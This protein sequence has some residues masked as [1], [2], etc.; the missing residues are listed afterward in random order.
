MF[1]RRKKRNRNIFDIG[2]N[3]CFTCDMGQLVPFCTREVVP[4]D[5]IKGQSKIFLRMTPQLAPIF[6][7]C[8]VFTH[9]FY[10]PFRILWK[11]FED[12]Y[13]GGKDYT[14]LSEAVKPYVLLTDSAKSSL[15][16]YLGYGVFSNLSKPLKCDA[17]YLRAYNKIWNDY[18][19]NQNLQDEIEI[20]NDDGEDPINN[21]KLLR[22]NWMKDIYT[23]ALPAPQKGP[24]VL[25]PLGKSAPVVSNGELP[26]YSSDS[27]LNF[28]LTTTTNL[29]TISQ[30]G[31][32]TGAAENLKY[33]DQT[34]LEVDLENASG[35]TINSFRTANKLQQWLEKNAR[36]GNRFIDTLLAHFGVISDD[37]RLQRAEYL[38]GGASQVNFS[39]VLQTSESTTTSPLANMAGHA[40]AVDISHTFYKKIKEPGILMGICSIMPKAMYQQG[41][42]KRLIKESRYDYLWPDFATLGDQP[43]YNKEL[44]SSSN[45]PDEIF[46]FQPR[47]EEYRRENDE[48]HGEFL[49]TMNYWT[50]ARIFDNQPQL[51]DEFI[52]CDPSKR[53]FPNEDKTLPNMYVEASTSILV[54]RILPKVAIPSL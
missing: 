24:D 42:N 29:Q 51:N 52:V 34:G 37:A 8:S 48:I 6:G 43:I 46:G 28:N 30:S 35:A 40:F 20:R 18:Y 21:Y 33:G 23:S 4:G 54:K 5:E 3:N 45:K 32:I 15:T 2:N 25:L 50:L 7:K 17:L 13:T 9:F 12:Y 39:E 10:V 1:L 44:Y 19:R 11:N 36:C 14:K 31:G 47:Y 53:I 27:L 16:D 38:G 41:V 49:D 26:T 22:R